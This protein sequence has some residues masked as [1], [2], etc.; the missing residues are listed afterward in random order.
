M[1]IIVTI[2]LNNYLQCNVIENKFFCS[3]KLIYLL[4]QADTYTDV[5]KLT[6]IN[7]TYE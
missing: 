5:Y 4:F 1:N 6:L 3:N 2:S 7:K